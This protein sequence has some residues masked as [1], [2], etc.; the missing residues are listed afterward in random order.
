[1]S[2]QSSAL[3][4]NPAAGSAM[5]DRLTNLL[6]R[7]PGA[8]GMRFRIVFYRL[9]GAKITGKCWMRRVEIAR[10]P[11]DIRIESASLDNHV[12]LLTIGDRL[13]EPRIIVRRGVYINRFTMIDASERIEICED[14]MIGPFCYITDHDHGRDGRTPINQ[15]PLQSRPVRIGRDTW[16]GAG[17][18]VLKGVTIGDGAVIGAG[19]VVT[20]DV[21]PKAVVA[22]IPARRLG[23]RT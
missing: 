17:V 22:G 23:E 6:L 2:L 4:C 20:R 11:W 8:L 16:L 21:P 14:A 1:M 19:A 9:L 15:Q 3:T 12:V 13:P 5:R 18:I 7:F 10:N